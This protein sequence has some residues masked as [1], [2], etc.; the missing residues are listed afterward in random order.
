MTLGK[1]NSRKD[2]KG[3]KEKRNTIVYPFYLF[4]YKTLRQFSF[5]D[6]GSDPLL[7]TPRLRPSVRTSEMETLT[8][9]VGCEDRRV[10]T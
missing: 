7:V 9:E 4:I 6:T 2:K 1:L 3:Q 5:V 8:S 10:Y